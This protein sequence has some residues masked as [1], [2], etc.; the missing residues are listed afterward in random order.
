MKGIEL[1]LVSH[2][3]NSTETYPPYKEWI[4]VNSNFF[5]QLEHY[6]EKEIYIGGNGIGKY[7]G[8]A[9]EANQQNFI[10]HDNKIY[11]RTNDIAGVKSE[12]IK[13]KEIIFLGRNNRC[14]KYHGK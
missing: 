7:I 9:A 11:F 10:K 8:K 13:E 4:R 3:E 2:K 12:N 14:L 5:L 6:G 1:F